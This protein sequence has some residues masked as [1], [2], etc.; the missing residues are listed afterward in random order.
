MTVTVSGTGS[1]QPLVLSA[2]KNTIDC[3]AVRP[4]DDGL[5]LVFADSGSIIYQRL[6]ALPRIRW[7]TSTVVVDADARV[8]DGKIDDPRLTAMANG[9]PAGAVLLDSPGPSPSGQPATIDV[10]NDSSDRITADVNASGLGLPG[11]GRCDARQ[12]L[13]S[14]DRRH[15]SDDRQR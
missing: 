5:N 12:G 2:N 10:R 4:A 14:H 1:G 8:G 3:A 7:A 6:T 15:E 11:G 9:L 13:D